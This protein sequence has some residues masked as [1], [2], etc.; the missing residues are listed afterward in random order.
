M[1]QRKYKTLIAIGISA[2]L[3]IPGA[4]ASAS[5]P[6]FI[7]NT[8]EQFSYTDGWAVQSNRG[9]GNVN[10]DVAKTVKKEEI[11]SF[12]FNGEDT[13]TLLSE[14]SPLRGRADIF[15]DEI[16]VGTIDLYSAEKHLQG[17]VFTFSNYTPGRHSAKIITLDN[18]Y[19]MLDALYVEPNRA[20][21]ISFISSASGLT[22]QG[23]NESN[24]KS[25]NVTITDEG[26]LFSGVDGRATAVK[27]L[28]EEQ[29]TQA[30]KGYTI[31]FNAQVISGSSNVVYLA[32]NSH[33]FLPML[34]INSE[35]ALVV[36]LEGGE[37]HTLVATDGADSFHQYKI[38]FD[39]ETGL[40]DF[41]F[42]GVV[43]DSWAGISSNQN[44]FY[45]GNGST[46]TDGE[47]LI[48]DVMLSVYVD[49]LDTDGDGIPDASDL[50]DDDDGVVDEE[51]TFPLDATESVDT[52]GDGTGNNADLDDDDD[53]VLDS[54]DAF[55]LDATE[56]VD[57]D[58][59]GTGN[60][61]DTDDDDDGI[62][63]ENDPFPLLPNTTID[64]DNDG[65]SDAQEQ[66]QG[67]DP[68]VSNLINYNYD[69]IEDFSE[70]SASD[71]STVDEDIWSQVSPK[72]SSYAQ[73]SWNDYS[74]TVKY[75]SEGIYGNQIQLG[76]HLSGLYCPSY[77]L[78]L[79][80]SR[81]S[82]LYTPSMS[83]HRGEDDLSIQESLEI[84]DVVELTTNNYLI[85][86]IV[87]AD[88]SAAETLIIGDK[89]LL[90]NKVAI[91]ATCQ[92]YDSD[93][94]GLSDDHE[95]SIGTLPFNI[96]S[97]NDGLNDGIEVA[98][99]RDPLD[100]SDGAFVDSDGDGVING[101]DPFMDDPTEWLDTDTDGIGNNSDDD[102]DNDGVL[103]SYDDLP[104]DPSEQL[105][106]DG[107]GIGNNI[108]ADDDGDGIADSDDEQPLNPNNDGLS[109]LERAIESGDVANISKAELYTAIDNELAGIRAKNKAIRERI[110]G[111]NPI[112]STEL[113][114]ISWDPT[115][116]SIWQINS[117]TSTN[118]P[119]LISNYSN[120]KTASGNITLV[121]LGESAAAPYALF[122]A[123]P[124]KN[125]NEGMD[126]LILNVMAEL[127]GVDAVQSA[128]L[129][130]VISH[131]P[132]S[133]EATTYQWMTEQ[134]PSAT[135]NDRDSCENSSLTNCLTNMDL[136]IIGQSGDETGSTEDVPVD[137]VETVKEAQL[138]GIPVIYIHNGTSE[139]VQGSAL[140]DYFNITSKSNYWYYDVADEVTVD[141]LITPS[142]VDQLAQLET[143]I[144]TLYYQRLAYS[145]YSGCITGE[146]TSSDISTYFG[147]CIK[148]AYATLFTD[149]LMAPLN[150]LA[151]IFNDYDGQA[152]DIFS[153]PRSNL[154]VIK[155]FV[156]LGDRIRF[157][158]PVDSA[159]D[160]PVDAED[161]QKIAEALTSDATTYNVRA[162]APRH[163][164]LGNTVCSSEEVTEGSCQPYDLDEITRHNGVI[165]K[166]LPK[167]AD[168][169]SE[170]TSTGFYAL[171]GVP[172]TLTRIDNTE[173]DI[174]IRINFTRSKTTR[175]AASRYN[176]MRPEQ[177]STPTIWLK[178]KAELTV[179]SAIGG[180]IYLQYD[181]SVELEGS[182]VS[183]SINNVGKH[184]TVLD[185]N[186]PDEVALFAQTVSS[187]PLPF[188]D[189]VNSNFETHS[190][191][192]E[193]MEGAH[194]EPYYG[195]Y[196]QFFDDYLNNFVNTIYTLAG[197][198]ID[199]SSLSESLSEDVKTVCTSFDWDCLDE[200]IHVRTRVQHIN[201]NEHAQ[202]GSGC[203]GN[204]FDS[205]AKMDP[206]GWL[207]GHE[208]GHN[209]QVSHL[210]INYVEEEY[211]DNWSRYENRATENS[212]HIFPYFAMWHRYRVV[213]G[214]DAIDL[215]A[216][217]Q[218]D[219]NVFS[220]IQSQQ[221]NLQQ[222][223]DGEMRKVVFD[224]NC[225]VV[226]DYPL[227][228]LEPAYEY[229]YEGN[230][231]AER[232][233]ERSSFYAQLGQLNDKA[234]M[235]DA[236]VL[237]NGFD[238]YTLLYMQQ[239]L[240]SIA[241]KSELSWLA[242]RNKLGFIDFPYSQHDVYDGLTVD[243]IPGNDYLVVALAKITGRDWRPF[244]DSRLVKY[245]SLASSAVDNLLGAD[246][247]TTG[248]AWV[249][250]TTGSL[251]P[252]LNMSE[253]VPGVIEWFELID[254]DTPWP[255]DGFHPS[256][257]L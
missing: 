24:S 113:P 88:N 72:K 44:S 83:I 49:S 159:I 27:V 236:T 92:L 232:N 160:Y 133:Y 198:K 101:D 16:N 79:T 251:L 65:I 151:E 162:I 74:G 172:F 254:A 164:D 93:L 78:A 250:N 106:T 204:P 134:L 216:G 179:T 19:F 197:F 188:V 115:T 30:E 95:L 201:Y 58:G 103:D 118:T 107:D 157:G 123:N 28:T 178:D 143:I 145:D 203:A 11:A 257:C 62:E 152:F 26:A 156:L 256:H 108:D 82:S 29:K 213:E 138:S 68:Y 223:I 43:I 168:S 193:F 245:S 234:T 231:Y 191:K 1:H 38:I 91:N 226:A 128:P 41:M 127:T 5:S 144:D 23:F 192:Y 31:S 105:D 149:K 4:Y 137:V 52:D 219:K 169:V 96:D 190:R 146:S 229:I 110:Y 56:S 206:N 117:D 140:L 100:L 242:T 66:L 150:E 214:S 89:R 10:D 183:V 233:K 98:S 3:Q 75:N 153:T 13:L 184:P 73:L 222:E 199:G 177:L 161:A 54:V 220:M 48:S 221:A 120:K 182:E 18:T 116:S 99:G 255:I 170:F 167:V 84:G 71:N 227:T 131:L 181:N 60:N 37:T 8:S 211:R 111:I 34:A 124:F 209:L 176:Y 32:N 208:L 77:A 237:Q 40:A 125:G 39:A 76:F 212:N 253:Q 42:D 166:T 15:V 112:Y 119:L 33:R 69:F 252:M 200:T 97:D 247:E 246:P 215:S 67:S 57:T 9:Y 171:P 12:D 94:D 243:K 239:R 196:A 154:R 36:Q 186:D 210:K 122:S 175:A 130:V 2:A 207:E 55:P 195:D 7:N 139:T 235:S 104:L 59:D 85:E 165:Q 102:D 240:F 132:N 47:L 173:T 64:S 6:Y 109:Q 244:F 90:V 81:S 205:G 61:A 136:L 14:F 135:V 22:E 224:K 230:N 25:G 202:C 51:D 129:N 53:G 189:I 114:A 218:E 217:H 80:Y 70:I 142:E 249:G 121:T 248:G 35:G 87:N 158:G 238:I 180:P 148:S 187:N 126:Q 241:A 86:R 155:L 20:N 228:T 50:D 46:G 63:D 147:E 174:G 163:L 45:F 141:G 225:N 194:S 185:S 21:A 17:E